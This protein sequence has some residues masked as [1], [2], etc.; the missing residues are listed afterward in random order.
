[1]VLT[2][3]FVRTQNAPVHVGTCVIHTHKNTHKHTRV[4]VLDKRSAKHL[5]RGKRADL[6]DFNSDLR[7]KRA[8]RLGAIVNKNFAACKNNSSTHIHTGTLPP[9]RIWPVTRPILPKYN[10]IWWPR[11]FQVFKQCVPSYWYWR[12]GC[13]LCHWNSENSSSPNI[14]LNQF[15]QVAVE[16]R[17]LAQW[18]SRAMQFDRY[19][20]Q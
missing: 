8:S 11:P 15:C 14:S 18:R 7:R 10:Q 1:M 9:I 17:P 3:Y 4:R 12:R 2:S 19:D 6:S 13:S 5:H 16:F 20:D